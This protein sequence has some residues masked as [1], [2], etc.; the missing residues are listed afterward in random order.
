MHAP[1]SQYRRAHAAR[2]LERREAR[3]VQARAV[4]RARNPAY[5]PPPSRFARACMCACAVRTY[6]SARALLDCK[7]ILLNLLNN[8][9]VRYG[10]V[11]RAPACRPAGGR[12]GGQD[13][14]SEFRIQ[15]SG[16]R[17]TPRT[18]EPGALALALLSSPYYPLTYCTRTRGGG[19]FGRFG[20]SMTH[21]YTHTHTVRR[22]SFSLSAHPARLPV[23]A[24]CQ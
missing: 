3:G 4:A 7:V 8:D 18:Q 20:R 17:I 13:Q 14:N 11:P 24:P 5:A 23:R 10:T 21:T 1:V 6:V 19:S 2:S 16:R 12:A 22:A 15:D 9:T